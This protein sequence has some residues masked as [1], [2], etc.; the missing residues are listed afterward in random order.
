LEDDADSALFPGEE[1]L[2]ARTKRRALIGVLLLVSPI[3]LLI[4]ILI[5]QSFISEWP[6]A[7]FVVLFG[8]VFS[9]LAIFLYYAMGSKLFFHSLDII[10]KA[11]PDKVLLKGRYAVAK[12]ANIYLVAYWGSNALFFIGYLH[13]MLAEKQKLKVPRVVWRWEYKI[14]IGGFKIARRQGQYTVP[15]SEEDFISGEGIL[16]SFLIESMPPFKMLQ[17]PSRQQI[18][19]IANQLD[20]DASSLGS[21]AIM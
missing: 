4:A 11:T 16:Y 18:L 17:Y 12:I 8:A 19:Q 13:S 7:I 3:F 10:R 2:R 6:F 20:E 14:E 5:L 9:G 21:G 15:V 1:E